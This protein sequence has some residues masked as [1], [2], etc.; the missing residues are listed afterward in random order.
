VGFFDQGTF[1]APAAWSREQGLK[2]IRNYRSKVAQDAEVELEDIVPAPDGTVYGTYRIRYLNEPQKDRDVYYAYAWSPNEG[3]FKLLDLDNMRMNA[4]NSSH[5][6][7]GTLFGTA[8]VCWP[9]QK[10]L[11][12][13]SLLKSESGKEWDLLEVTGINDSGKIV[14]Y[15]KLKGKM[16]LFLAEP[17]ETETSIIHVKP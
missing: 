12:L 6:I 14:G 8:A 1:Q 13:S 17:I 10:P 5:V 11:A 7:A 4:V 9:G 15:G 16:R 3:G 2:F